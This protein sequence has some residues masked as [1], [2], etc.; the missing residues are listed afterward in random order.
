MVCHAR[1]PMAVTCA[2]RETDDLAVFTDTG[3]YKAQHSHEEVESHG[4]PLEIEVP[5]HEILHTRLLVIWTGQA[6]ESYR[7]DDDDL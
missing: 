1:R 6:L 3:P 4:D 2:G 7:A 5:P